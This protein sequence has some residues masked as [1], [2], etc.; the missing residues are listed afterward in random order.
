MN[1]G[2]DASGNGQPLP[3]LKF[4]SRNEQLVKSKQLYNS[5]L[6]SLVTLVIVFDAPAMLQVSPRARLFETVYCREYYAEHAP[7]LISNDGVVEEQLCKIV[8]IQSK[9]RC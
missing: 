3:L 6:I 9:L 8:Q 2:D 5:I 1:L 7:N 4:P